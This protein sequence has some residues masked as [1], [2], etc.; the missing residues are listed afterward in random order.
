M[1]QAA[2]QAETPF[3]EH[4]CLTK[5][6]RKELAVDQEMRHNESESIAQRNCPPI[7]KQ[8]LH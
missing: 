3:N 1:G 7:A 2:L 6:L 5:E 4:L 8:Q